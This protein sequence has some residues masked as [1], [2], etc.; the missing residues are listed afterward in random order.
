VDRVHHVRRGFTGAQR[1]A[2]QLQGRLRDLTVTD[3][4]VALLAQL[5]VEQRQVGDLF[6]D[7]A[8]ALL[9]V[10]SELLGYL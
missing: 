3:R 5:D 4:R 1:H 6:A 2:L 10:L 7:P 9:D 8:K